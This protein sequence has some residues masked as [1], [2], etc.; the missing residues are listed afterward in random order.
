MAKKKPPSKRFRHKRIGGVSPIVTF[1]DPV[2]GGR[3][4]PGFIASGSVTPA[5][6]VSAR[7][8]KPLQTPIDGQPAASTMGGDW[9][10]SF[11]GVPADPD[12]PWSLTITCSDGSTST[13]NIYVDMDPGQISVTELDTTNAQGVPV[14]IPF[15][16]V[17]VIVSSNFS[18]SGTVSPPSAVSSSPARVVCVLQVKDLNGKITG[19]EFPLPKTQPGPNWK[20]YFMLGANVPTRIPHEALVFMEQGNAILNLARVEVILT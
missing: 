10:F 5:D 13:I 16:N 6:I 18:I 11:N 4:L 15:Q 19:H 14:T 12:N 7:L 1:S 9:D 20:F 2:D 8:T 17:P 3:V